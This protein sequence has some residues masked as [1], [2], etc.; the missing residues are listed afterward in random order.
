MR[1]RSD[2]NPATFQARSLHLNTLSGCW[3]GCEGR[4]LGLTRTRSPPTPC[5][6]SSPS[7]SAAGSSQAVSGSTGSTG[8]SPRWAQEAES[9]QVILLILGKHGWHWE[10][11]QPCRLPVRLLAH[12]HCLHLPRPLH[13][14]HL[15][16][17][18]RLCPPKTRILRM[19]FLCYVISDTQFSSNIIYLKQDDGVET[20]SC[21]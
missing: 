9:M 8:Q 3:V 10:L 12:H 6:A 16:L 4:R 15:L 19:R 11:L 2:C 5:R 18:H 7:S 20:H 17:Q 13:Q 1:E 14:L 21:F